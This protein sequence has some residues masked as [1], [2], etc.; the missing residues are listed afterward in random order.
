MTEN[1]EAK[2]YNGKNPGFWRAVI[3]I[4]TVLVTF[5][6]LTFQI[7]IRK[8]SYSLSIGD[9]VN[10]DILAP[11]T[12]TFESQIL[13]E[14]AENDAENMVDKIYLPADPT[15]SRNQA[16]YL[17]L[18]LQFITSVRGDD[19]SSEEQKI[20]D[21]NKLVFVRLDDS[22]S[23]QILELSDD[24]WKLIQSESQRILENVMQNSIR[25][26][27]V[28][29][30]I[31]NIPTMISYSINPK[32][33]SL[34]DSITRRFVIPNSLYSS[35][36][37]EQTRQD[38]RD[39][40]Q[41]RERT[42][43]TNQTVVSRG[44]IINEL[45]YEALNKM[46]LVQ[47]KND[48]KKV[49][50]SGLLVLALAIFALLFFKTDK[51]S[52]EL[53]L[54]ECIMIAGLYLVMLFAARILIPNRTIIPFL[55][56]I[57]TLGLT[58]TCLSGKRYG[59]LMAIIIGILIPYDF[60]DGLTYATF[61]IITS[62]T[63]IFVLQNARQVSNFLLAGLSAGIVGIP[64]IF[65][66]QLNDSTTDAIGL[67]TLLSA[68]IASGL[69]SAGLTLILQYVFSSFIGITTSLQLLELIRP[70]S[71]LLQYLLNTAP[72]T[73]QHSLMVANLSEQAA[74]VIGADPLLVRAGAMYHDVGKAMNPTYFV[75]NQVTGALN[76]HEDITPKESAASIIQHVH[77]GE[78]LI[79]KY[80]LPEVMIDFVREH[81]GT[82]ITRYQYT[83]AVNSEGEENVDIKDF[84]YPGPRPLTKET[85]LVMLAD[86]CEAKARSEK[87][88]NDDEIDA[89][90]KGVFDYYSTSGQLD[91]APLTLKDLTKIRESFVKVLRNSYHPRVKYPEA[92]KNNQ[93]TQSQPL[94]DPSGTK[95]IHTESAERDSVNSESI[96]R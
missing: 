12:I 71:P 78:T 82:N 81:H 21:I 42:F 87:P 4:V 67:L 72:G 45:N 30:Q 83:Q 9:V 31:E 70:D 88:K 95:N 33:A 39:S 49:I 74:K 48:E 13:T 18:S 40:V 41:P 35:Q 75:E 63:G 34:I 90:V 58:I 17:R 2:R 96:K 52:N 89:L 24:D 46:G 14:Q 20:D 29:N 5:A 93:H 68:S 15:I 10:Q 7:S 80:H 1:A 3:F 38:A 19:Y 69:L 92:S 61:Y 60:T 86:T 94:P 54:R 16:Q 50:S 11:R 85:A 62:L 25:D 84:T 79:R 22:T 6:L 32:V 23:K 53:N 8:T 91:N 51:Q 77:D 73:Y 43:I 57:Q 47:S 28:N 66:F 55:F 56:P 36:L 27:Q 44:Q 37:T 59:V 64:I 26:D 65:A 76:L